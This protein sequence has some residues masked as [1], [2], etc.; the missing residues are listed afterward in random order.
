LTGTQHA[1]WPGI[2]NTGRSFDRRLAAVFD[3]E[4]DQMVQE[5][6]YMDFAD[7]SRQLTVA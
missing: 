7:I 5:H 2:P 6:V 3:F 4:G 1:D